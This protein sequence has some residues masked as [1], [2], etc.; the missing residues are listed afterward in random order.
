VSRPYVVWRPP[1]YTPV[2]QWPLILFLHGAGERG[3]DGRRQASVGIGPALNRFPERFPALV[4][5][6]QCPLT[7]HWSRETQVLAALLDEVMNTFPIDG[8][9]VYLTG[10]SMGGNGSFALAAAHPDRFA[11]VVPICGWGAPPQ[12]SPALRSVPIWAFHGAVDDIVP[13]EHSREMVRAL[14]EAGNTRVRYTEYPDLAHVSWD[15]AYADPSLA[16]WLFA[17]ERGN[18]GP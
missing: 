7:S 14:A 13:A 15:A 12:M 17:Q 16:E 18:G 10:I 1:D 8:S 2:R 4:V 5:M 11:A 9:R 3:S 6:P